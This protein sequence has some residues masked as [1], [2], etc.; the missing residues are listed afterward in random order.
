MKIDHEHTDLIVC[1]YCGHKDHDS[2]EI[3]FG[4]WM[5]GEELVDC[6][7]CEKIFRASRSVTV[8]YSTEKT[9]ERYG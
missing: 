2:W 5:E 7:A 1:P 3:D 8:H 6:G 9:K 4:P